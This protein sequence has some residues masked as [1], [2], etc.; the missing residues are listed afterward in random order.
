M[1]MKFYEIK[2]KVAPY[3][4]PPFN[5]YELLFLGGRF[6]Y[7]KILLVKNENELELIKNIET[8][9]EKMI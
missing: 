1:S 5:S 8:N 7:P 9:P 2:N 3:F 4:Y 6:I